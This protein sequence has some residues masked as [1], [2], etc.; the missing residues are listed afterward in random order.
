MAPRPGRALRAATWLLYLGL[1]LGLLALKGSHPPQPGAAAETLGYRI[2]GAI[3]SALVLLLPAIVAI[4]ALSPFKRLRTPLHRMRIAF[5]CGL[6]LLAAGAALV[7]LGAYRDTQRAIAMAELRRTG[8][9]V[10]AALDAPDRAPGD[11]PDIDTTPR[12]RGMYGEIERGM[13][14]ILQQ[15]VAQ[16]RAYMKEL[17]EAR[18]SEL[19]IANRLARDRGLVESRLILEQSQRVVRKYSLQNQRLLA[20]VPAIL[21]SLDLSEE[22]K[23]QMVEGAIKARPRQQASLARNWE[24]E[25]QTLAEFEQMI[26]LLDDN[27]SAW[28]VAQNEIVFDRARLLDRFRAHQLTVRQLTEARAR[29]ET[30]QFDSLIS[31]LR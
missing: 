13:K 30:Q 4:L 5:A 1:W 20:D 9:W 16:Y 27:R 15:R 8:E 2:G 24:L 31:A 19:F 11:V 22:Q 26:N 25:R 18:L 21:R 7:G 14:I 12:A 3:G 10:R 28:R 23:N 17:D 29:L 6:L